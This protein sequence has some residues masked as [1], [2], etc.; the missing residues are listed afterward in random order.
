M[1]QENKNVA[2]GKA[3]RPLIVLL[4]LIVLCQVVVLELLK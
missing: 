4:L 1:E 3:L 2:W